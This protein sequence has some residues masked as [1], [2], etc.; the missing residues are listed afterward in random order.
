MDKEYINAIEAAKK[1]NLF[2]KVVTSVKS[3]DSYNSFFNIYEETEEPC[4][5]IVVLTKNKELEEVYD[6][7]P[8]EKV[9]EC[10]IVDGNIWIKDY[11]LLVSPDKIDLSNLIIN[12][13]LVEEINMRIKKRLTIS[14][15]LMLVIPVVII[16]IIAGIMNIPFSKAYESKFAK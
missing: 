5:R 4:R 8:T 14:N 15:I 6:E 10:K 16:F 3:F 7:N 13:K 1:Y 11:S 12:K 9:E 2:L